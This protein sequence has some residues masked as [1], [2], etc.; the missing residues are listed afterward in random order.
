MATVSRCCLKN[1]LCLRTALFSE[2]F[3]DCLQED[4]DL[5]FVGRQV[6]NPKDSRSGCRVVR[7]AYRR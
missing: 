5:P 7:P 6:A 2:R 1:I 4:W 3:R